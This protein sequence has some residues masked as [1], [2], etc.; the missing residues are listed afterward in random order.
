[1]IQINNLHKYYN[2]GKQNEQHVLNDISL[3]FPETGLVCILG[4]SGSGKTT[5][6]NTVGG[7]DTFSG[8]TISIDETVLAKYDPKAVEPIRNEHF[9]YIFQNYYLLKDYSVTYNIKLAL[10]RYDLTEEEKDERVDYVLRTLGMEKYKKKTVSKLSGGQ[11]QRVSIARALIKSPDVIFADEPTGNLDEENTIRTMSILKNISKECLV[12]LVSHEKR[13]ARF[14]ADRIIEVCDG[15][16]VRDEVNVPMDSY[17]RSDDSNI[18]L[19]EMEKG[20]LSGG[21][22]ELQ[23]YHGK[24]A[25]PRKIELTLAWKDGKLFIKN[26][27]PCDIV[28]EG[29][30]NGV[31]MLDEERPALELDEVENFSYELPKMKSRGSARLSGREI[32]RMAWE[33]ISLMGKKQAFVAAI[34]LV[35]AVLLSV[36][37]AQ[38]VNTYTIDESS[39]IATD[40]HYVKIDFSGRTSKLPYEAREQ[41]YTYVRETL[42]NNEYGDLFYAPNLNVYLTGEGY[43]QLAKLTQLIQDYSFVSTDHLGEADLLCG[44]MPKKRKDVVMD[45]LLAERLTATKSSVSTQYPTAESY[46]GMT[47]TLVSANDEFHVVGISDT[48]Q[49]VIYCGQNTLLGVSTKGYSVASVA[50]LQAEDPVQF[51]DISLADDEVLVRKGLY[52]SM[53]LDNTAVTFG[54]DLEHEYKIVGTYPDDMEVNYI[55][56]EGGC[57]NV[58]NLMICENTS[59][60]I[61]AENPAAALEYFAGDDAKIGYVYEK[62]VTIPAQ[63]EVASYREAHSADLDARQLI[64]M[65]VALVSLIMVYFTIKSNVSSRM[66]ELTVYRLVGISRG[67]ILKAYMLEMVLLTS[68]TSLP[69]VLLTTGV[70]QFIRSIPSLE[71]NMVLPWWSSLV[72]LVCI[73]A[74]HTF[75]SI[76]PVYGI[77]SQPPAAL[78]V[79]E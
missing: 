55:L 35:T 11:Q 4:E 61:Y 48:N 41:L 50:E 65:A 13:I 40:S 32:F 79:K 26:N 75:I 8:G 53:Q 2:K 33:N 10:S 58:R 56:S 68:Y 31:Q 14:F 18:Y 43:R 19:R 29:V 39:I 1:M 52:D 9:D 42:G 69:A 37:M 20:T 74:I 38:F 12:L 5:L 70:I 57:H 62:E 60:L 15:K 47:L 77:L 6:L 72:L 44:E 17:E 66:E 7:L 3:E 54:D 59:C 21:L 45:R 63:E 36:T 28:I 73:Y 30:E 24:D 71:I 67:S 34:L 51:A 78:A 22:A 16:I 27:M 23:I 64:P 46:L 49:P 25:A 76:L